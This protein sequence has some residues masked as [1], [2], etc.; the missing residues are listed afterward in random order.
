VNSDL[1]R[2]ART[3]GVATARDGTRIAYTL[4]GSGPRR[5]A[6]VHS[7]A[8]DRQFW[9]PVAE[10]LASNTT[11]LTYDCRGHGVSGKPAGPYTVAQFG[12]D[13][14]DLF[15]HVGWKSALVAG[16]SMGGCVALA[17]AVG[18][19]AR[20]SALGLV[21]T[22]PWYGATA[23]KDW[24]ERAD[25]AAKEG[26]ASLVGFQTTR[27]FSDKFRAEHP[28]VVKECVDV[29]LRN[30]VKAYGE[31]CTMLGSADQRAALARLTMPT[32]VIVGEEDYATPVAMA[33]AL[34]S[35][36]AGSTLNVLRGG[37]H[38]TPLEQPQAIAAEFDRLLAAQR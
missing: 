15:D 22:T 13:L 10:L 2:A 19:P 11:V 12:D 14:A 37:R 36:I 33:Q 18:Y 34:H 9:Q 29:F 17:F 26:L 4:Q 6:L 7:L 21:D 3:D 1:R 23:P 27:W 30:D 38:L 24:A 16:A 8:M 32:A 25:K 31:T 20:A 28:E 35:G 5:A